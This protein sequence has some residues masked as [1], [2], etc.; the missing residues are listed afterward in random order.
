MLIVSNTS[1]ILN[2]AIVGRLHLLRD[3]FRELLIPPAVLREL[4]IDADLPGAPLI[5]AA[6]DDGWLRVVTPSNP[7]LIAVLG[8]T[9]DGGEAE[10]IALAVE[11]KADWLLLDERAARQAAAAL[12]LSVTGVVGIL[13]KAYRGSSAQ[14]RCALDELEKQAGFYLSREV[15]AAAIASV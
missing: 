12:S 5:R 4:R 14:F 8:Q 6:C 13:L 10:A 9:L 11:K 3:Q 2:L 7:A 1:P 15:K